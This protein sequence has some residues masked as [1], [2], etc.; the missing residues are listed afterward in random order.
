MKIHYDL[1]IIGDGPAGMAA[2]INAE[3]NGL[4]VLI[5][6]E[7]Q[8]PGGQIFRNIEGIYSDIVNIL[9]PDYS[10]GK[11]LISRCLACSGRIRFYCQLYFR[12]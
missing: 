2:A 3:K 4:S 5:I 6:G 7:Q 9:G 1:V 8:D 12:Q 10:K 11:S